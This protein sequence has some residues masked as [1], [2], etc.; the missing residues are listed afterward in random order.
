MR[1]LPNLPSPLRFF[2]V[3][4]L[5]A[6]RLKH[7]FHSSGHWFA[8]RIARSAES[9][10]IHRTR[11]IASVHRIGPKSHKLQEGWQG[12]GGGNWDPATSRDSCF[13]VSKS[14]SD[15]FSNSWL[16]LI[17]VKKRILFQWIPLHEINGHTLQ[18]SQPKDVRVDYKVTELWFYRYLMLLCKWCH[19]FSKQPPRRGEQISPLS[20]HEPLAKPASASQGTF[21]NTGPYLLTSSPWALSTVLLVH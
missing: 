13:S 20:D 21:P 2:F 15:F 10:L 12:A 17:S 1:N 5:S 6:F 16:C 19:L 7:Y 8:S 4:L 9:K 18:P 14:S 3:L 11:I